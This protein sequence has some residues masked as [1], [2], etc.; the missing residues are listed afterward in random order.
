MAMTSGWTTGSV[1]ETC[2]EA[3]LVDPQ[4]PDARFERARCDPEPGRSSVGARRTRPRVAR[5]A[6]SMQALSS[7]DSLAALVGADT[8]GSSRSA[9]CSS[10][11]EARIVARSITFCSSRTLPGHGYASSAT[12]ALEL[13]PVMRLPS[14]LA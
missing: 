1:A 10:S 6:S 9:G 3:E 2:A 8:P 14:L 12:S 4:P 13:R 7:D 11:P 5:N